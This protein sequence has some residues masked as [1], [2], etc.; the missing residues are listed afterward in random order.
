MDYPVFAAINIG[1]TFDQ[2]GYNF[3]YVPDN[4]AM[5]GGIH[6]GL[7]DHALRD[8]LIDHEVGFYGYG[9]KNGNIYIT[10]YDDATLRLAK[11]LI[12]SDMADFAANGTY[13]IPADYE[14]EKYGTDGFSGAF[15]QFTGATGT[16][17]VAEIIKKLVVDPVL[18]PRAETLQ[19]S[20]V[21][22][23]DNGALEY[24]YKNAKL[25]DFESF[26]TVEFQRKSVPLKGN[27]R[28]PQSLDL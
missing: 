10:A 20:G 9:V 17:N 19:L 13:L 16:S 4:L 3:T 6:V 14:F 28:I 21:V 18:C 26:K 24:Y 25:Q 12:E 22:N 7:T 1:D 11:Q 15:D 5:E 8:V 2:S 27:Q 23:V